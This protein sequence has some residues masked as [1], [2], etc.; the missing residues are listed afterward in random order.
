MVMRMPSRPAAIVLLAL[1]LAMMVTGC[2]R[3]STTAPVPTPADFQ[4]IATELTRRG[5]GIDKAV[6]GDAGCTDPALIPT[7]IG[8]DAK[9]LDQPSTVR[10][11]LYIFRNRASFEKL[12]ASIDT[13]ASAFITDPESFESVEQSPFVVVGQ[14]PWGTKFEAA[15][16]DAL[17]V[18]AG[19]GD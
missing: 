15:I 14:G 9:G 18:A 3:I 1:A 17:Q 7:A 19:T 5:I 4:G 11:Y 13:C 8:L 12:R 6:S 16:R 2:G 10:L